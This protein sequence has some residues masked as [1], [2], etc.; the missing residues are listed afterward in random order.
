MLF[1]RRHYYLKLAWLFFGGILFL[2]LFFTSCK[3]SLPPGHQATPTAQVNIS[4]PT[5]LISPHVLTIGVYANYFP[6]EYMDASNHQI[7]GFDIDFIQSIAS[8][9]HLQTKFVGED[10]SSLISSLTVNRFDIVISAVSITPELQKNVDFIPYF[11]GGESLLVTKGNPF[12]IYALSDLCGRKVAIKD[13]TLEQ[14]EVQDVSDA[15]LKEGKVAISV[16]VAAQYANALQLLTRKS[17]AAIYQDAPVS[18]Y[19][20]KQTP[21]LFELGGGMI[22]ANIEGVAVRK[23]DTSLLNALQKAFALMKRDGTYKKVI[24]KWGLTSGDITVNDPRTD[25]IGPVPGTKTI[26]V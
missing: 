15:C 19:S 21:N 10:Y 14:R 4:P 25:P 3:D 7:I 17:V 6:Q 23:H 13:G 24:M 11:K 16:V 22:G 2:S 9:L 12:R 5:D 20:I 1:Y 26:R 8:R 18:D